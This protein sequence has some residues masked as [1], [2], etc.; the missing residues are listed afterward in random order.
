VLQLLEAVVAV[1]AHYLQVADLL[2]TQAVLVV[3]VV[4]FSTAT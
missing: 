3:A 4:V 2:T 1:A